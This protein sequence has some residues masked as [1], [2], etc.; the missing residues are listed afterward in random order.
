[1]DSPH[2]ALVLCGGRGT[3]LQ[4]VVSDRPKFLAPVAGR[5]YADHLLEFL[6]GYVRDVVLCT[7]YLAEQIEEYCGDGSRWGLRI[8]YSRETEELGTAGAIR[9]A[10][11]PEVTDPFW[12]LNGD[13]FVT[14]QL[15]EVS[16]FHARSGARA[17]LVVVEVPDASR[18]GAVVLG[19]DGAVERFGEKAVSG[20][21][22]INAGIYLLTAAVVEGVERGRAVSLERDVLPGLVGNG[23]YAWTS[24]GPFID[25][26]TEESFQ[27]AQ[28]L[29]AEWPGQMDK[30]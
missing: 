18:F 29:L 8:R 26:G 19:R 28:Q 16:E 22:Y 27:H 5:P 25:I 23:L 3:R 21:G 7:G 24:P 2:T 13:S 30:P 1:M 17:A 20:P 14:A 6:A 15:G 12:V 10:L 11:S 4:K 9:H